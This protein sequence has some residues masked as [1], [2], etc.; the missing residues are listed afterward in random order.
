MNSVSIVQLLCCIKDFLHLSLISNA[1][2][3]HH[4]YKRGANNLEKRFKSLKIFLEIFGILKIFL[5][6]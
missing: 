2:Y 5:E 1:F 3:E 6:I 4:C